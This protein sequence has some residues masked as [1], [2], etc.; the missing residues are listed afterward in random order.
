MVKAGLSEEIPSY[1]MEC[2]I[3]ACPDEYF[4]RS[5]WRGVMQGCLADI[6]NYTRIAEP[7]GASDRWVEVNEA[8]LLF[9]PTQKWTRAQ[10]H[11][12]ANAAWDYMEFE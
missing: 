1:L 7:D 2:L 10:V 5:T 12:F 8:K 11:A 4:E 9:H 6:Y 3:Y